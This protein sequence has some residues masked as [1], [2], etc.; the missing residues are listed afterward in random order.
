[1]TKSSLIK[2]IARNLNLS[3]TEADAAVNKVFE[4]MRASLLRGDRVELRGF[5]S[6]GVKHLSPREGRNPKTGDQ[7]QVEAKRRVFFKAGKELRA[8]VDRD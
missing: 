7:V 8:R 4:T 2:A 6:F 3:H 5:G 1:M